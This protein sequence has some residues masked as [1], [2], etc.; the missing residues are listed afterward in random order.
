MLFRN[1]SAEINAFVVFKNIFCN[2]LIK[3]RTNAM[4][5]TQVIIKILHYFIRKNNI[6]NRIRKNT[7]RTCSIIKR[8]IAFKCCTKQLNLRSTFLVCRNYS[9]SNCN[10]TKCTLYRKKLCK[11]ICLSKIINIK[12]YVILFFVINDFNLWVFGKKCFKFSIEINS[13]G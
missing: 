6:V 2:I 13:R 7:F 11:C 12:F 1:I 3:S 4:S 8:T 5:V 10:V 9:N